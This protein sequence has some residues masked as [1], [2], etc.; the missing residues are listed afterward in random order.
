MLIKEYT[1]KTISACV[2]LC[3]RLQS[4]FISIIL[5]HLHYNPAIHQEF[6]FLF[7]DGNTKTKTV[8]MQGYMAN[9]SGI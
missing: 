7:T 5:F 4:S 1:T 8:E 3:Y 2:R 9:K 6:L